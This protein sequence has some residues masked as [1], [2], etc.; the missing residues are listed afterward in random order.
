VVLGVGILIGYILRDRIKAQVI[1][2]AV[3]ELP[4]AVSPYAEAKKGRKGAVKM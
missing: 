3:G 4:A 2:V 1:E